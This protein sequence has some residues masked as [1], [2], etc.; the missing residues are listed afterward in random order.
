G[1][2]FLVEDLVEGEEP[3]RWVGER[4]SR[5]A[6]LAADLA[7]TLAALHD[8]GFVHGDVKPEN[9]RVAGRAVL[10][11]LRPALGG[12]YPPAFAAPELRAG[13]RGGPATDL[14]ALGATLWACAAKSP[15][16]TT[17]LRD[18]APWVTPS[19]ADLIEKLMAEH[20]ADRPTSARE[21]LAALGRS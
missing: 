3:S 14:Y 9:V 11:D 6:S 7:E 19:L 4:A 17:T 15:R 16:K 13:G 18:R 21:V 20:P 8:A 12:G 2:P 1:V 5:L 10:L